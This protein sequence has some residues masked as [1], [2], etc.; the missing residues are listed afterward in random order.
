M[1]KNAVTLLLAISAT[2][3]SLKIS[4]SNGLSVAVLTNTG[5]MPA[6]QSLPHLEH[7][8]LDVKKEHSFYGAV[9]SQTKKLAM[10]EEYL[11]SQLK[12]IQSSLNQ[13]EGDLCGLYLSK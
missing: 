9:P 12:I 10:L 6:R 8:H 4:F 11:A 2:L 13:H 3:V 5:S 1:C 7:H